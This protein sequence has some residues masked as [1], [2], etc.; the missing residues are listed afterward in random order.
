METPDLENEGTGGTGAGGPVAAGGVEDSG[1]PKGKPG[2]KPIEDEVAA[3]LERMGLQTV[4]VAGGG[5][6]GAVEVDSPELV[7]ED[8]NRLGVEMLFNTVEAVA[9]SVVA[10]KAEI[11]LG[12][13]ERAK[14]WAKR[15]EVHEKPKGTV[16]NSAV[17][18]C[19]KH[20]VSIGPETP[21]IAGVGQILW[22]WKM[23]IDDLNKLAAEKPTKPDA[24]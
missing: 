1:K 9:V 23:L 24:E 19:S 22:G 18:V 17:K 15:A 4:P 11:I 5:E 8:G 6:A 12:D 10:G 13:S 14:A 16:I 3:Y 2:R 20:G 7:D 21:L